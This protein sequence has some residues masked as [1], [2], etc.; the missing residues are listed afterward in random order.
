MKCS[1]TPF[2]LLST[3]EMIQA[4]SVENSQGLKMMLINYGATLARFQMPDKNGHI[5][6]IVLGYEDM[7]GVEKDDVFLGVTVGRFA[8]RIAKGQFELNGKTYTLP[9]NN[10]PNHLHGGPEGFYKKIWQAEMIENESSIDVKFTYSSPD[11]EEGYPGNLEASV[12][13]TL[14]EDNELILDYKATAD[15]ATPINMTNHAYWNLTGEGE[16]SIKEHV[17]Q[18]NCD[19][20]LVV[21]DTAIPT[22]ELAPVAGTVMDFTTPK[23]V[24]EDL[25]KVEGGYDHCYVVNESSDDLALAATLK[26]PASGRAMD[27]LTTKPGIQFYS[28]NFLDN[29]QGLGGHIYDKHGA[30][31]LETQFFPDAPNQP[32]FPSCILNPGE[33]YHQVTKHRFYIS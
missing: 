26:D 19:R 25:D 7:S 14:T 1:Q 30:L 31:C 22:G 17:L 18:L 6:D 11:G 3:G 12:T 5:K 2:G 10:G 16:G 32:N 29:V 21:D 13:Y 27:I 23:T 20:Y 8:N 4:Y 24:G 15:Q 9:Q 28:G 33:T